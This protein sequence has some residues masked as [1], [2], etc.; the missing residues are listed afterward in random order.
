MG[1]ESAVTVLNRPITRPSFS[2]GTRFCTTARSGPL[3]IDSTTPEIAVS[4]ANQKNMLGERRPVAIRMMP[5]NVPENA[6]TRNRRLPPPHINRM[7]MPTS[8]NAP[9]TPS[10]SEAA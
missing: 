1:E 10:M 2:G 7:A 3:Y 8:E 5:E 9:Y 4:T 6:T